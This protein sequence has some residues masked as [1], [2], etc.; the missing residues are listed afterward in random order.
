MIIYD[1][2]RAVV[3][4][5]GPYSYDQIERLEKLSF[6][7]LECVCLGFSSLSLLYKRGDGVGG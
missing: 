1:R 2:E 4:T 6:V 3:G 5:V 7:C